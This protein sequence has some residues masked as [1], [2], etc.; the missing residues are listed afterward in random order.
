MKASTLANFALGLLHLYRQKA[1][2][3]TENKRDKKRKIFPLSLSLKLGSMERRYEGEKKEE[4]GLG[5]F[6]DSHIRKLEK[7]SEGRATKRGCAKKDSVPYG[8]SRK[9]FGG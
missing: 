2:L 7:T 8:K 4:K 6:D 5:L 9:K 3:R 1:K